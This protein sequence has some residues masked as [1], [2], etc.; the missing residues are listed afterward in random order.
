M[1]APGPEMKWFHWTATVKSGFL[2]HSMHKTS[3][4]TAE[5]EW[6]AGQEKTQLQRQRESFFFFFPGACNHNKECH[7]YYQAKDI[8]KTETYI[9][10]FVLMPDSFSCVNEGQSGYIWSLVQKKELQ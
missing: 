6:G 5:T 9:V 10:L 2:S 8:I 1:G 3:W 7:N 4:L